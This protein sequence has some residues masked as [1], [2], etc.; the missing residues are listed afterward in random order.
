MQK[1]AIHYKEKWTGGATSNPEAKE[2]SQ[3]RE[4]KLAALLSLILERREEA[5]EV[6]Q[7]RELKFP[8]SLE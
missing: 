3:T 7:T 1:I 5:K 6:S 2:V 4:L 8:I